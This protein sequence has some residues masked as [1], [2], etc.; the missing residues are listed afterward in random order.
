[1]QEA[2]LA[3]ALKRD[4]ERR[5]ARRIFGCK[6]NTVRLPTAPRA[7]EWIGTSCHSGDVRR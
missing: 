4:N 3:G 6:L 7:F 5:L 2:G 1:M